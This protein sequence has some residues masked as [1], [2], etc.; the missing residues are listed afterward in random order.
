MILNI[1]LLA[2]VASAPMNSD[3][4]KRE[5]EIIGDCVR[6]S[7][8]AGTLLNCANGTSSTIKPDGQ[9]NSRV[10]VSHETSDSN[11]EKEINTPSGKAGNLSFFSGK[12][13]SKPLDIKPIS[14]EDTCIPLDDK[15]LKIRKKSSTY[16][17]T[18][19][20]GGIKDGCKDYSISMTSTAKCNKCHDFNSSTDGKDTTIS[21]I[22]KC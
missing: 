15:A 1:L 12:G 16:S 9:S 14:E 13:C 2:L 18:Y 11:A 22:M 20:T 5:V 7:G 6:V 8:K 3:V 4:M 10:Y 17:V 21:Y 19:I